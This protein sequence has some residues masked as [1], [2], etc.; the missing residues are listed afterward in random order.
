MFALLIGVLVPCG[1]EG[2]EFTGKN[3][4]KIEAEIVSKS[5]KEVELKLDTGKVVTVPLSSLSDGDQLFVEVWES[6]EAKEKRLEGLEPNEVLLA[7][8]YV[9]LQIVDKQGML[10]VVM[11]LDGNEVT[12]VIDHRNPKPLLSKAAVDRL[13][14]EMK[15]PEQEGQL[16]GTVSPDEIGNGS[17]K[18]GGM[19]FYVVA[20]DKLPEGI[21]GMIG[22]QTFVDWSARLDFSAKK[23]WIK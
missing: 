21:D 1:A 18:V 4:K 22:G 19:A 3:G 2:R 20:L 10:L 11:Q 13:G 6:S 14:L 15:A 23:L 9:P 8:G 17:E 7:K 12:L 5:G 16:L